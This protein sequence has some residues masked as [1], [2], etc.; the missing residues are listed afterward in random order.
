MCQDQLHL[1]SL[2]KENLQRA[3]DF[4]KFAEAKNGALIAFASALI[5]ATLQ[6]GGQLSELRLHEIVGL[7]IA[8]AAGLVSARSFIPQLSWK[9]AKEKSDDSPPNLLFFGDIA[10]LTAD[11][12]QADFSSRYGQDVEDLLHDLSV[13]TVANSRIAMDKLSHFSFAA[14][15]LVLSTLL[16]TISYALELFDRL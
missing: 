13:Q 16:I 10:K 7:C 14:L 2:H 15:L 5:L 1:I 4:L 6:I 11:E 12:F 9:G 3:I 8:L